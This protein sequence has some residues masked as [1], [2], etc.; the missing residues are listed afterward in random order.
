MH[1]QMSAIVFVFIAIRR[2]V[3][4]FDGPKVVFGADA[5]VGWKLSFTKPIMR[6]STQGQRAVSQLL[7]CTTDP[8]GYLPEIRL[9]VSVIEGAYAWLQAS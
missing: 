1:T 6:S 2:W 8:H 9:W 4:A 3:S 7:L 5:E